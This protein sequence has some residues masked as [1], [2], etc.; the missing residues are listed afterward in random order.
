MVGIEDLLIAGATF[1][2]VCT[3]LKSGYEMTKAIARKFLSVLDKQEQL[4]RDYIAAEPTGVMFLTAFKVFDLSWLGMLE[5]DGSG[6]DRHLLRMGLPRLIQLFYE[7]STRADHEGLTFAASDDMVWAAVAMLHNLGSIETGRQF[8]HLALEGDCQIEIDLTGT[9]H[10]S[11]AENFTWSGA[12]ETSLNERQMDAM[13]SEKFK[14]LEGNQKFRKAQAEMPA[15]LERN[16]WVYKDH[17]IGYDAHPTLDAMHFTYATIRLQVSGE[18]EAISPD[19]D[20][21]GVPFRTFVLGLAFTI[22]VA[23]KHFAF[24]EALAK[25]RPDLRS[26]DILTITTEAEEFREAMLE[27]VNEYGETDPD[28]RPVT[29]FDVD[30]VLRMLSCDW[31]RVG[32]LGSTMAAIP[33]LIAF[34]SRAWIKSTVIPQLDPIPAFLTSLRTLYPK[35]W[36]RAQ[37]E[38][39]RH[40]QN[41]FVAMFAELDSAIHVVGNVVLG[42]GSRHLTDLDLVAYDEADGTL[43]IFQL[44]Y[45]D[46]YRGDMKSRSNK[47]S[48]LIAQSSKWTE[49]VSEWLTRSDERVLRATLGLPIRKEPTRT[50]LVIVAEHFAHHLSD[51]SLD[52]AVHGTWAQAIDAFKRDR[53]TGQGALRGFCE[54]LGEVSNIG[55]LTRERRAPSAREYKLEGVQ[56]TLTERQGLGGRKSL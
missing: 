25:K 9:F 53:R 14:L 26:I 36:D 23:T 7:T 8:A 19:A 38:R 41:R 51:A 22:S 49:A 31:E 30:V 10:L 42:D 43:A 18:L 54:K 40:M 56:F 48:R 2:S 24:C 35:D 6:T 29:H 3:N 37:Q 1:G 5:L 39:E 50:E 33:P 11:V 28:F 15:L 12:D 27:A 52:G 16:V 21:G 32:G 44:K 47:V 46:H 45:Q 55:N 17:Y 34:S 13:R 20:F 4:A